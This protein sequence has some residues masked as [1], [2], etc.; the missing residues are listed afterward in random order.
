MKKKDLAQEYATA[1][2]QG[3]L[4]GNEVSFSDNKIFTEE[5]IEDAFNAGQQS[6]IDNLSKLEWEECERDRNIYL[7]SPTVFGIYCID[8]KQKC[9]YCGERF[10]GDF[11][12]IDYMKKEAEK[13]FKAGLNK[14]FGL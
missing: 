1:R 4:S 10:I 5:D 13:D 6:I 7:I 8:T 9:L 12:N 11:F 3:R 2:L 14:Y